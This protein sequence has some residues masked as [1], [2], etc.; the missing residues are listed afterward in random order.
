[1]PGFNDAWLAVSASRNG[2]AVSPDLRPLLE[3]VYLTVL[4]NPTDLVELKRRLKALLEFLATEG[5]TNANC[6]AVDLFFAESPGWERDWTDQELP[7]DFQDVFAMMGEALHD[8]VSTPDI[9]Q[10]FECLPE[11]LLDQVKRLHIDA[12]KTV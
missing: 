5:R 8:T 3:G 11:Q 12:R 7:D 9:A 6:W 1:L 2:E 10:N 4:A